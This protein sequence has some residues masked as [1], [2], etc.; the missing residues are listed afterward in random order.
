LSFGI[1]RIQNGIQLIP[2]STTTPSVQGE[3]VFNSG[4]GFFEIFDTTTRNI[5][6]DTAI[7][8]L[9][10][11]TLTSANANPATSGIINLGSTEI[12][13]WR[14]HA[15]SADL[16]LTTNTSDQLLF[17]G[18]LVITDSTTFTDNTVLIANGSG[19]I[20][21]SSVS[22][23]TL[24]F[25]DATSSIQ[26][27][28]N[29]KASFSGLNTDGVIYASSGTAVASTSAGS[30]GLPLIANSGSA[31]TF[32]Q[33]NLS[34]GTG[35]VT[36]QLSVSNGGTGRS[37]VSSIAAPTTF[38]GWD[39]DANLNANTFIPNFAVTTTTGG[40]TALLVTSAGLQYFSGTSNQTVTLPA[41]ATLIG[42][43]YSIKIINLS[44]GTVTVETSGS[45][46]IQ[47]MGPNTELFVTAVGTGLTASGWDWSY[48]A[49]QASS[50]PTS[51]G[52]T[53]NTS[54]TAFS[55]LAGGTTSTGAV[56]SVSGVGS[57]GQVLT[58]NGASALPTWQNATGGTFTA[59]TVQKFIST[60]TAT[61]TLF[62]TSSANATVGATY[63][64]NSN[65]FTVL[66][67]ISAGTLLFCSGTGATSGTTLTKSSGTGDATITFS[68]AVHTA[69][70]TT[71]TSPTPLYLEV[72]IVGGGGGGGGSG[73][74]SPGVGGSGSLSAFGTN[75]LIANGG[76]GGASASGGGGAGGAVTVNSGAIT[77]TA[78]QGGTG[79][80]FGTNSTTGTAANG[81]SGA[82]NPLGGAGG[83]GAG[84]V[85][86]GGGAAV[87]NSGGGGGGAGN[88]GG[89]SANFSGGGGSAGGYIKAL[90]TS[91][92][93]STYVYV[94]GA[95]GASG[96]AG[97]NGSAGGVGAIGGLTV[98]AYYQ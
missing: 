58:S 11:K 17:N 76:S 19:N 55:V 85:S 93:A 86:G 89:T 26:T 16:P 68:Q 8:A 70:Y 51:L 20:A 73:T 37:S 10:N 63:T 30:P 22:T 94:I 47:A 3:V 34:S 66:G 61:G 46:L 24:G 50:L 98:K 31:P 35:A 40:T 67:T 12:V 5:V 78:L 1:T 69:T 83:G 23:T 90:I 74:A 21:S 87:P 57:S 9:T 49:T 82:S 80:S 95:A 52:G 43:G 75:L 39:A 48:S 7:Q 6:L 45:T 54:L 81:G 32:Q 56:Q 84:S 97:T 44:T 38:A 15:N 4:T 62:S 14:N 64:N 96:S 60:G 79:Q 27:Q 59:P 18:N 65:T 2:Q 29:S 71:P 25:L 72:E 42:A 77:V 13:A 53:G 92:I 91:S 28:L 33:L 36:S 41:P 88:S